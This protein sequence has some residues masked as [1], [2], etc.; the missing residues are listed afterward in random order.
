VGGRPHL[1]IPHTLDDNNTRLA[2]GPRLGS[3]G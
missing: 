3:C 1:I 2:K